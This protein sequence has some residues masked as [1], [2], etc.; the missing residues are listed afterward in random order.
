VTLCAPEPPVE[1]TPN[2]EEKHR[3]V[4]RRFWDRS[5]RTAT[6]L[7]FL[8]GA[9]AIT[10]LLGLLLVWQTLREARD[11]TV[12]ANRAW[13]APTGVEQDMQISGGVAGQFKLG[14][15][16]P[17]R[18]YYDNVGKGPALSVNAYFIP[19][20]VDPVTGGN[21]MGGV[22]D[23][24]KEGTEGSAPPLTVFPNSGKH[25]WWS[26]EIPAKYVVSDV[27]TG[28]KDLIIQGC[29][30]YLTMSEFHKTRFC[31]VVLW[32]KKMI[33]PDY[34]QLCADGQDAN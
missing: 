15:Q 23:S 32:D 2:N 7:N 30:T 34:G 20:I 25:N 5:L 13:I 3:A 21:A 29:A 26:W 28:G 1:P 33:S 24:C 31:Y 8:T 14:V 16:L 6:C 9:A 17:V 10:G 18:V 19:K 12:W 22:N 27:I 4:E 11:S